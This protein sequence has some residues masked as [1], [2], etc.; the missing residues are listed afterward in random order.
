MPSDDGAEVGSA[1][2]GAERRVA[3]LETRGEERVGDRGRRMTDEQRSLERESES[4][5]G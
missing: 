5:R 4:L 3:A 1:W 2:E